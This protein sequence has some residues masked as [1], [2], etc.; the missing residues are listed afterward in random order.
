MQE[1]SKTTVRWESPYWDTSKLI[2]AFGSSKRTHG[3]TPRF[4]FTEPYERRVD[5]N[6]LI[7]QAAA[8]EMYTTNKPG[9]DADDADDARGK[10]KGMG[11]AD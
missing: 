8:P 11:S 1:I 5:S 7:S 3:G 6:L 10:V 9:S 4:Q 2:T